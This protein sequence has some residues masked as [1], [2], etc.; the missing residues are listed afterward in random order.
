MA[1]RSRLTKI[2]SIVIAVIFS[3]SL[4]KTISFAKSEDIDWD[5]FSSRYYYSQMNDAEKRLYDALY[6][7][8]M[9]YLTTTKDCEWEDYFKYY[10]T[11]FLRYDD[12]LSLEQ[13]DG[14]VRI[15]AASNPQ[16]YFL[17]G[18]PLHWRQTDEH[19]F[20]YFIEN[21]ISIIVYDDFANGIEREKSTKQFIS[22]VNEYI[23]IINQETTDYEK[24]RA[25]HNIIAL[26]LDYNDSKYDQS[27]ASAFLTTESVCAGYS[28]GLELLLNGVGIECIPVGSKNHKWLQV[29][30][31]DV[32]YGVDV[33]WDD[34]GDG[35]SERYLNVSDETL[36]KADGGEGSL[37]EEA[38]I[39]IEP[40][41]KYNR[42]E[43]KYDYRHR[44]EIDET[45][46]MYRLYN[47]NSGEHFYTS[48]YEEQHNLVSLG[49]ADEGTA[50][51]APAFS[52]TPVYR[53]YN[54]NSG[55]HHYTMNVSE[56]NTLVSL[57]WNDE[58]IGWYSDDAQGTP[59]YHL[60]NP[61]ATG[62][63]EAGGHHYTKDTAERD[64]LIGLG[65]NDE[66]IGWYGV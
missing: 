37:T 43:C 35:V 30:I 53:V 24:E 62:Q 60:Y 1:A 34:T 32:W 44:Y 59:L 20:D 27:S 61:N 58:G 2:I 25:A 45:A 5:S 9:E 50:W 23:D 36:H 51:T 28:A 39:P 46:A 65:W 40:Y 14:V 29:K 3:F 11:G 31:D 49:W 4:F 10:H 15:F 38:H 6:A 7:E 8:C 19:G 48:D 21:Y 64:R 54:P 52:T 55:E 13:A 33:T 57:G 66:G 41:T 18:Y 47:K 17:D 42:P 16:F 56:R 26:R 12:S 22:T 63:Y